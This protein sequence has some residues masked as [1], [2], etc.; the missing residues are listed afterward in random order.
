MSLVIL[1]V[2]KDEDG[3]VHATLLCTISRSLTQVMVFECHRNYVVCVMVG[4]K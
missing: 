1:Y 2:Q 4:W 3:I